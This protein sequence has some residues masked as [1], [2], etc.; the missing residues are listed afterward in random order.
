[1]AIKVQGERWFPSE[2]TF[3]DEMVKNWGHWYCDSEFGKLKA[4]LL[5]RPG[6]E[7]EKVT[8]ENFQ[9]FR[10][11]GYMD[12]I[13]ARRQHD[14]LAEMYRAHGVEVHY[15]KDQRKDRPNAMF[16]RD[17]VFMTPEG[18]IVGRP[19]IAP[20]RGEE[21]AVAATLAALGVPIIKTINGD[22]Y[23][24]GASA[25][26]I[27]QETVAIGT[28][29]RTNKSGA[30]Q[31]EAELRNIGVH[32][33]I[34]T[35][36]PYGSLHLD[37]IMNMVDKDKAVVFPWQLAYDLAM[38]LQNLGIK[39]IEL[40][41]IHEVKENLSINFVALGPSK[42]IMAAGNPNTKAILESEGIEVLETD[43]SE[44]LHGWG[45]VHCMTVF[46]NR[47]PVA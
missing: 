37:G 21:R 20:R 42:V 30:D 6:E 17:L 35:Q 11:R 2:L 43:F 38:E 46:L 22:G 19:G 28:S 24:E 13:I 27:N 1:M 10:F 32:N 4:V 15:V 18:A 16:M 5:H 33:V 40:T 44:L 41:D 45:A 8:K 3:A 47:E 31:V 12:P 29:S 9:D 39:L 36:L 14:A 26:W 25:M 23:F 7:I 34:R